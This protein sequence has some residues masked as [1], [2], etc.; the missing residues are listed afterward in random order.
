MN[1]KEFGSDNL[2][3]GFRMDQPGEKNQWALRAQLQ[4]MF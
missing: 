4:L 1:L 2:S 3:S